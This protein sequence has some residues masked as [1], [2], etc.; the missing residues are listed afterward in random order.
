[1]LSADGRPRYRSLLADSDLSLEAQLT[2]VVAMVRAISDQTDPEEM[3]QA[4]GSHVRR[5]IPSDGFLALSRRGLDHPEVLV[6]RSS[7]FTEEVNPW[8]EPGRL[9]RVSGGLLADLIY[10]DEPVILN[11]LAI[12]PSDPGAEHLEGY[13]S[14]MALPNYDGGKALNMTIRLSESAGAFDPETLPEMVWNSN[15][16]GRATQN[17]VLH[18]ELRRAYALV[19]RELRHVAAIQ[20]SLL[21]REVPPIPRLGLATSYETSQWAGGDYYDFFP[22]PDGCWGLL[23][24]DVSGHGTPAA[25]LMAITH[26]LAHSYP[27][28]PT[29]AGRLLAHINER[30][31]QL[32]NADGDTFVTA[33]YGIF[34]PTALRFTYASAGHNPPRLKRCGAGSLHALDTVG[35]LPLGLFPEVVYDQAELEL[36]PGDQLVLYTDGITEASAPDGRMYGT[37]RLDRAIATCRETADGLVRAILDDLAA[38]TDGTPIGDDRTLLVARVS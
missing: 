31:V 37:D 22:L 28:H 3:V 24:A 21:P 1:M 17:L 4:Y 9:P 6:T 20:R 2:E 12:D 5:L 35:G 36:S 34:D 19:D 7:R 32:Y 10:G 14:L 27:D 33:F 30:L 29:P 23:I 38:F 8:K 25:V 11:D 16:F 26:S 15:L 13:R 18:D